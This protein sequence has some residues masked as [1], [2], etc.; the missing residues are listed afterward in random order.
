MTMTPMAKAGTALRQ[1]VTRDVTWS[2]ARLRRIALTVPMITASGLSISMLISVRAPEFSSRV[3]TRYDTGSDDTREVPQLPVTR[4]LIQRPYWAISGWSSPSCLLS[5]ATSCGVVSLCPTRI[6]AA[7]PGSRWMAA[8]TSTETSHRMKMPPTSRRR[9]IVLSMTSS[10]SWRWCRGLAGP[11]VAVPPRAQGP[12]G[13][14][15][16]LESVELAAVNVHVVLEAVDDVRPRVIEPLEQLRGV[17]LLLG[18]V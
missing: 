1:S 6:V 4:P 15:E 18:W 17:R 11:D 8:K 7:L 2:T 13:R 12:A 9:R 16:R 14:V 3:R 5:E 10:R